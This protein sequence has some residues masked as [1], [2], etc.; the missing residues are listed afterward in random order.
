MFTR[1]APS[2]APWIAMA[3]QVYYGRLDWDAIRGSAREWQKINS[4]YYSDYYQL[5]EWCRGT[6][7]WRGWEFF[8][9]NSGGGFIQMFRPGDA[10]EERKHIVVKGLDPMATY[11]IL[12][13][14]TGESVTDT[15]SK[16]MTEGF[17][18]RIPTQ[19]GSAVFIIEGIS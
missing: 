11:R 10:A 15:G 9:P 13:Q 16:F 6:G 19:R 8:D 3:W 18:V 5:T 1:C 14:D 7:G 4:Y 12:N 2:Y 17:E